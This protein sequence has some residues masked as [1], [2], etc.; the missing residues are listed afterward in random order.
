MLFIKRKSLSVVGILLSLM[1]VGCSHSPVSSTRDSFPVELAAQ[2]SISS[3]EPSNWADDCISAIAKFLNPKKAVV[4][5]SALPDLTQLKS[6][7]KT[8]PNGKKYI[9]Y[10]ADIN[11]MNKYPDYEEFL[12][13]TVEVIF[14]PVEPFGHM[15]LRIGDQIYAFNNVQWTAI[16]KFAPRLKKSSNPEMP[17]SSGFVFEVGKEK[18]DSVIKE[19]TSWYRSSANMNIPPFDA[20]SPLLKIE[21]STGLMGGKSYKY[22]SDS[23]QFGNNN[24]L[25]GMVVE[26]DGKFILDAQNGIKVP[27]VKKGDDF[28]TQSYSCSSS[29]QYVLHQYFGIDVSYG[30]SAKSLHHSL[31]NGNIDEPQSP[32]AVIQYYEN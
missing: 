21:E 7:I 11:I 20:Y 29:A 22:V 13:N 23:P 28:Y 9:H 17:G 30:G 24:G 5:P 16:N 6:E 32:I 1:V 25:K 31:S 8:F 3:R 10:T 15:Q 4:A 19:V 27:L 14:E 12:A 26:I 2:Q 18:I